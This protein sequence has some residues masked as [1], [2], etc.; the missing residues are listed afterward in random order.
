MVQSLPQEVVPVVL[1]HQAGAAV[2]NTIGT[3]A[4]AA[5]LVVVEASRRRV[6]RAADVDHDVAFVQQRLVTR[7][8][9]LALLFG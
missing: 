2:R 3:R 4:S 1:P 9:E 6:V 8:N 7:A 5:L